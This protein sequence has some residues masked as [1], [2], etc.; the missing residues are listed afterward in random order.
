MYKLYP[1]VRNITYTNQSFSVKNNYL[2]SYDA[3]L[4]NV[5]NKLSTFLS[6]KRTKE[7]GDINFIYDV[8][9]KEEEYLLKIETTKINISY[10]SKS[11][12]FFAA[13]TLKQIFSQVEGEIQSLEINDYPDLA[14]RGLLLDISRNKVPKL[15]T[16]YKVVDLMSDLKMNHLELYVEGF[17]FEYQSFSKYLV[18][19]GYFTISEYKKLEEYCNQR[20]IDLVPNQNG[21]GHMADWLAKDEFHDLAECPDGAFIWGRHRPAATLDPSDPKALNLITKMYADMLPHSNSKYFNMNF[22][23]PMEL[24]KGKSK[25]ICAE[26][27]VANVYI[28]FTLKAYE[29]IKK[30]NKIPL[31]WGDVLIHHPESLNRLPKDMLFVD[32]GYDSVYPFSKN[33]KKLKDLNIKFLAAPATTSWCSFTGRSS[34]YIENINNACMNTIKYEGLGVILT[35][36]GDFGHLQF[37]P[38]S[39]APIVYLA[40][41]SWHFQEG[42]FIKLSEYMN[43]YVFKDKEN[44]LFQSMFDLGNYNRYE[45]K[46]T[47]NAT[48]T[49]Y[50]FMWAYY[51]SKEKDP[52]E[53]YKNKVK[54]SVLSVN[55]FN[56]LH[57]FLNNKVEEIQITNLQCEDGELIKKELYQSIYLIKNIQKVL[58]AFNEDLDIKKRIGYLEEVMNCKN[59]IIDR[60]QKLWLARNKSGGLKESISLLEGFLKFAE[61]TLNEFKRGEDGGE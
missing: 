23:E 57:E 35:D 39:Y 61:Y 50:A 15:E 1:N 3:S 38:I 8:S 22:D 4:E 56:L 10:K 48:Y 7:F 12:A 52:I 55:K 13:T 44:L 6:V 27:G 18:E 19:D 14:V 33:L 31:I 36:W 58:I 29:E 28:D 16:V 54:D 42:T 53:Y 51:A 24:G 5:F 9:L 2:V 34:E 25:D 49:F 32:W 17:S 40:M 37:L 47:T 45:N 21:F 46:Y 30:Y 11:G 26:K 59:R 20:A 60:Q 41:T 43:K